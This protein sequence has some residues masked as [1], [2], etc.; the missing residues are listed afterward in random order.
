MNRTASLLNSGD[1]MILTEAEADKLISPIFAGVELG[2]ADERARALM[3]VVHIVA[4]TDDA[5]ER[6]SLEINFCRAIY[7]HTDDVGQAMDKF[8]ELAGARRS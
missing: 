2:G 1:T 5:D 3:R 6:E 7:T 8:A 4:T